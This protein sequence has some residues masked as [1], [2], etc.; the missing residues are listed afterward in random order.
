MQK[1]SGQDFT[2]SAE[3]GKSPQAEVA[4]LYKDSA[5]GSHMGSPQP[6]L[7]LHVLR[8]AMQEPGSTTKPL[9]SSFGFVHWSSEMGREGC[10]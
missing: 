2:T 1:S 7:G 8:T 10:S 6:F 3:W 9:R 4:F 5:H